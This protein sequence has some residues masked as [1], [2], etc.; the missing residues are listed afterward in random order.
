METENNIIIGSVIIRTAQVES[1]NAHL[2]KMAA[3]LQEGAVVVTENQTSGKGRYGRFWFSDAGSLTFSIL[4]RPQLELSKLPWLALFAGVSVARALRSKKINAAIKWPNDLELNGRKIGG[5][6]V[7]N[8]VKS[9]GGVEAVI[10]IGLNVNQADA[11]FP[12]EIRQRAG[13]L[14]S[15]SDKFFNKEKLLTT[16]LHFLDEDYHRFFK[17]FRAEAIKNEWLSLCGHRNA[18]VTVTL[19]GNK[20]QGRFIDLTDAGA[21]KLIVDD[22][23]L[24]VDNFDAIEEFYAAD[25]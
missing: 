23:Q 6:L 17:S 15:A 14:R 13:S 4:I 9:D 12:K 21:A 20:I 7:E 11:D 18:P 3:H 2:K 24:V 25:D 16:L 19:R 5:I 1:T 22:Q 10:G 8:T